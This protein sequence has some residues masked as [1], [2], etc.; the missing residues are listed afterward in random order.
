M[1]RAKRPTRF[2]RSVTAIIAESLYI[3]MYIFALT[4]VLS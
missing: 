3:F 4:S 1:G 2:G